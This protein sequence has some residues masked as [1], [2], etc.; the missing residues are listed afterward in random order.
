MCR[1][2]RSQGVYVIVIM[3]KLVKLTGK[4]LQPSTLLI[5]LQAADLQLHEKGSPFWVSFYGLDKVFLRQLFKEH[6]QPTVS[7]YRLLLLQNI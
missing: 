7:K 3:S 6:F 1:S 5:M 4:H 2:S